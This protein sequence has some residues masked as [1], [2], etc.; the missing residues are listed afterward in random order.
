MPPQVSQATTLQTTVRT[1]NITR[2]NVA[3]DK[4]VLVLAAGDV[5]EHMI[6]DCG[7]KTIALVH[8]VYLV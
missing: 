6:A 8:C 2:H 7:H 3:L 5:A 1:E 4:Q